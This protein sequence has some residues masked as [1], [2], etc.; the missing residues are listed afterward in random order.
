M[1]TVEKNL[2]LR[3]SYIHIR[4]EYPLPLHGNKLLCSLT[5]LPTLFTVDKQPKTPETP[6]TPGNIS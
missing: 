1:V 2:I 5:S 4:I 6:E 3:V